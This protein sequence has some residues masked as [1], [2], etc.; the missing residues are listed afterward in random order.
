MVFLEILQMSVKV[1]KRK[2]KMFHL[3]YGV[4]NTVSLT[5]S[6]WSMEDAVYDLIGLI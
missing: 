6:N 5:S 3:I 2:S 1:N 4:W